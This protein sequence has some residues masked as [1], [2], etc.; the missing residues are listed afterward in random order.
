MLN[1]KICEVKVG[2]PDRL[3]WLWLPGQFAFL[4]I[5]RS[6][7]PFEE[8]PFTISSASATQDSLIFTIK[9]LGDYTA[10]IGQTREGDRVTV[11]GPYGRFSHL[12]L[13]KENEPLLFIAGG[14]GI[15]PMLAMLRHMRD[16]GDQRDVLL[17]WANRRKE[18]IILQEELDE[19]SRLNPRLQTVITLSDEAHWLGEKGYV[20]RAL[21]SRLLEKGDR[22]RRVFLCGPPPMMRMARKALIKEGFSPLR[23]HEER[24]SL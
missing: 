21:L 4:T 6:H 13:A 24:F 15:T 22:G 19:M 12:L 18:D 1:S 2:A 5:H 17:V 16:S 23:I 8:H 14:V 3:P 7:A 9:N 10:T 11:D 20:D